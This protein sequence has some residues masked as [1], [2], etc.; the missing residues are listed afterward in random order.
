MLTNELVENS[1]LNDPEKNLVEFVLQKSKEVSLLRYEGLAAIPSTGQG[2]RGWF[3]PL[4]KTP[5]AFS[6]EQ[7]SVYKAVHKWRDDLARREDENP[8]FIMPQ[9]VITDIAK[10]MPADPKALWS[11]FRDSA[12]VVRRSVDELFA[13]V[14]KAKADGVNG[15]TMVDFFRGDTLGSI[16]SHLAAK[17]T[18][19]SDEDVPVAKELRSE[20][21]QLWGAVPLSSV[22]DH[23][24]SSVA[25]DNI[26]I[27]VPWSN[28][29]QGLRDAVP[30]TPAD[31]KTQPEGA[32]VDML[33]LET[34]V[35]DTDFTLRA[36]RKRKVAESL[37]TS[38][39][40]GEGG[41][42]QA[43]D[44]DVVTDATKENVEIA[45]ESTSRINFKKDRKQRR[46]DKKNAIPKPRKEKGDI[47]IID[48]AEN[49]EEEPF[50]YS[51]AQSVLHAKRANNGP[52][53][54]TFDPYRAKMAAEG[55][56]G[57]RRMQH[58]KAG[59]S[60]TFKK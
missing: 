40:S 53:T 13:I 3:N 30:D 10:I 45:D 46:K 34:S 12:Q 16:A 43:S 54:R 24:S 39:D 50:D 11:L 27:A 19:G 1:N 32:D 2:P 60:A 23:T 6:S 47:D 21:S 8:Q 18:K 38:Q 15:P 17:K 55:P 49:D 25:S 33:P 48:D 58:E 31:S 51:K 41:S 14:Q 36:G 4:T 5:T 56:K 26:Q 22:W 59:K 28:F 20:N 37:E 35:P 52:T 42:S 57:A 7:F 9:H 29:V 44:D